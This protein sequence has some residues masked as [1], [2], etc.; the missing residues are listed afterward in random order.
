M[1][2]HLKGKKKQYGRQ[3]EI[4]FGRVLSKFKNLLLLK[5]TN[6]IFCFGQSGDFFNGN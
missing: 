5:K 2:S 6:S 4:N 1:V 3:V